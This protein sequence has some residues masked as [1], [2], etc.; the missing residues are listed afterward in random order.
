MIGSDGNHP[1]KRMPTLQAK[2]SFAA[3]MQEG[4]LEL[5]LE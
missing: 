1:N 4:L 3:K 2:L 5:E